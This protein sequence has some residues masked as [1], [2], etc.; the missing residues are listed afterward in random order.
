MLLLPMCRKLEQHFKYFFDEPLKLEIIL[1]PP[2]H[3]KKNLVSPVEYEQSLKQQANLAEQGQEMG[4]GT[5][6]GECLVN[7][8]QSQVYTEYV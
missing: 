2:P 5:W 4:G 6:D 7:D 1:G 3:G 8:I